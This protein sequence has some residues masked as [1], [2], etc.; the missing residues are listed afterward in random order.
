MPWDSSRSPCPHPQHD[1]GQLPH[2]AQKWV[3]CA[4]IV[5][6]AKYPPSI[7]A[8]SLATLALSKET[9]SLHSPFSF[10]I[11][12]SQPPFAG[13][14]A[15][16]SLQIVPN[17]KKV[18]LGDAAVTS[19]RTCHV[20]AKRKTNPK[21]LKFSPCGYINSGKA[22]QGE[23][24]AALGSG[25]GLSPDPRPQ[26]RGEQARSPR[27]PARGA[28]PGRPLPGAGSP[29]R[30]GGVS[31][32]PLGPLFPHL[33]ARASL[34]GAEGSCTQ[35]FQTARQKNPSLSK[36]V[37]VNHRYIRQRNQRD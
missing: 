9:F 36:G 7:R 3:L 4:T 20:W 17:I 25:S 18:Q 5:H 6:R 34:A 37:S 10:S 11:F 32:N 2:P 33:E 14:Q 12:D 16:I 8:L 28:G 27:E 22:A 35:L 21:P 19:I 1:C 29:G 23:P 30:W 24:V 15:G 26:T 31:P 13:S